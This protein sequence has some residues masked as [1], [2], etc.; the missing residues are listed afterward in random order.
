MN[1]KRRKRGSNA[2]SHGPAPPPPRAA[3]KCRRAVSSPASCFAWR[4]TALPRSG[5]CRS[6]SRDPR[7][8]RAMARHLAT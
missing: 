4:S 7:S 8:S 3:T 2:T 1:S 5:S 6:R